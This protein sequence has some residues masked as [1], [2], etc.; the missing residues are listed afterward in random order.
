VAKRC[1]IGPRLLLIIHRKSHIGFQMTCKSSILD[2]LEGH[3]QPVQSVILAT[4]GLLIRLLVR[5]K[6]IVFGRTY[7]LRVTFF[8]A[9]RDLRDARADWREILHDGQY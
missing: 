3:W 7:V 4:A 5:P 1:K 8:L 2:D 9:T 6:T